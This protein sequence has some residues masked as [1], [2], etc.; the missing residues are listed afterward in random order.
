MCS[1]ASITPVRCTHRGPRGAVGA[2]CL[3]YS[4]IWPWP[5]KRLHWIQ[6]RGN[7]VNSMVCGTQS[8]RLNDGK[9]ITGLQIS[10]FQWVSFWIIVKWMFM[11]SFPS[12]CYDIMP[13]DCWTTCFISGRVYVPPRED[14][15]IP[16]QIRWSVKVQMNADYILEKNW[17]SIRLLGLMPVLLSS[18]YNKWASERVSPTTNTSDSIIDW[19]NEFLQALTHVNYNSN[20]IQCQVNGLCIIWVREPNTSVDIV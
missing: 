4:C 16:F 1:S 10:K 11:T 7:R 17:K 8:V 15:I 18:A 6:Y 14:Y 5:E 20:W 3:C 13:V 2:P 12:C 9:V 19:K